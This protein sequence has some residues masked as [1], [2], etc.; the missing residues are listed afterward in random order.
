[1]AVTIIDIMPA[2]NFYLQQSRLQH[3][4]FSLLAVFFLTPC[5]AQKGTSHLKS[6]FTARLMNLEQTAK[7]PFRYN[8][9]LHNGSTQAQTYQLA[10]LLPE[11]WNIIFQDE[12]SEVSSLRIDSGKTENISLEINAS[13]VVKPGKYNIPV[14]AFSVVDTL[15]LEL[16]AVVKGTYDVELTTPTGLLSDDVTEG[17]GKVLQLIV[18]NTGTLPLDALSLSNEAPSKWTVTFDPLKVERL[19]PGKTQEINATVSVPDKT[20]A[21]DYVT[22]FTV[23]NNFANANTTFRLTVKTSLLSGWIGIL[24]ILLALGLVYYLIRKYGRR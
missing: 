24:I 3:C 1:M 20:I 9:S 15:S 16:E 6:S 7:Q 22:K 10:A 8:T 5:Y 17:T 18:K 2:K 13:P 21:G 14:T 19:D 4:I 12:G 23:R 11:G